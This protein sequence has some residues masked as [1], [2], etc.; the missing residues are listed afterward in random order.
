MG[1]LAQ[2]YADLKDEV[3]EAIQRVLRRARYVLG[4][5]VED[6]E[7]EFARYCGTAQAVG[8]ASGTAALHLTLLAAGVGPGDQVITAANTDIAT[9]AA[10]THTGAEIVWVDVD[11]R[12]FTIDPAAIEARVTNRTR[13]IIPVHLFGHPADM[14]RIMEI[15]RRRDLIVVED[16]ALAVGATYKGSR[17]GS[18]GAAGCFSLAPGKVFG[19]AGDAGVVVTN[20]GDLAAR[21]RLLRNY[22]YASAMKVDE[23]DLRGSAS[24]RAD[25][26]GFNER[27]DA[28]QAAILRAKLPTLESRIEQRR[29]AAARYTA[30]LEDADVVVPFVAARVR[31]VYMAYTILL[32]DRERARDHLA[33]S[34]VASRIYYI[35]PLHL[36]PAY[37]HL[38]L[39]PGAFPVTERTADLMLSLPIFPQISE[40]EIGRV[41]AA[42][43][44]F[45]D[46]R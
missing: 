16:A 14:D 7:S 28:L 25:I 23:R 13:A 5:E 29:W 20:D 12:T 35:P 10:I 27:L 4:E 3:D 34:G 18:I 19:A 31:H 33:A 43:T 46:R 37:E 9:T 22:G 24:W 38:G 36:Q 6:F 21:L 32:H 42:L 44:D 2:E 30:L 1:D 26:E 40:Q 17:V 15:A 39:G 11:A 45:T 41:V 8:V